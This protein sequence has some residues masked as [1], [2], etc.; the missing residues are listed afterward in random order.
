LD[1]RHVARE[2]LSG[3]H[4]VLLVSFPVLLVLHLVHANPT[5]Q[6][7][8]ACLC[9]VP[10]AG[11]MGRSTEVLAERAGTGI[12][13]LLNATFGNAAELIIAIAAIRQGLG[14]VV[15]ASLI[16]SIIGNLL[17]VLGLS[18]LVGGVRFKVQK[19][20]A[21]A[22]GTGVSMMA[23]AVMGML[24]P[25]VYHHVVGIHLKESQLPSLET[26]SLIISGLLVTNYAFSLLFS[27]KTHR[28]YYS[29]HESDAVAYLAAGGAERKPSGHKGD[30]GIAVGVLL[31]A[32]ACI[33]VAS[34][35]LVGAAEPTIKYLGL[36]EA[37]VGAVILAVVGNAAEH[38]TAVLM[39]LRNK[40]DLAM[41]ICV[42][43]SLQVAL[44]V[45]PVLVFLSLAMGKPVTLEFSVM[46]IIAVVVSLFVVM[47]VGH[48]GESNWFEGLQL[49]SLYAII[50]VGFYFI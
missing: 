5:V 15:K 37:F 38:S 16:G 10:L 34:E 4:N 42:G 47:N 41:Q 17:F 14:A 7:V 29:G 46:E 18:F 6:F 35:I 23:V 31:A 2:Y 50:A 19:F 36:R 48:D 25:A 45:T 22:A 28:E 12:G 39:A 24:A 21:L 20:N 13:G 1:L 11:L 9:I 49:I 8:V 43:S 30:V 44:F 33:A 32:T 3:W 27:L 26:M 40:M